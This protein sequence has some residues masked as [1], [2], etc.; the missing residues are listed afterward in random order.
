MFEIYPNSE[1][2]EDVKINF[3]KYR[4][5]DDASNWYLATYSGHFLNI[6]CFLNIIL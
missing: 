2:T 1:A 4:L 5:R 6:K 3:V